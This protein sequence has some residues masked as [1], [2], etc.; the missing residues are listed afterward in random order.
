M[1]E[2]SGKSKSN[3]LKT[4]LSCLEPRAGSTPESNISDWWGTYFKI[5]CISM[6]LFTEQ[7]DI[8]WTT[9]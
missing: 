4:I 8:E 2:M 7:N 6:E 3:Q 9:H 5:V 1:P